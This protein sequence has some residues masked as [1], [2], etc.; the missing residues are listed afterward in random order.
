MWPIVIGCSMEA[1]LWFISK[2]VSK[3]RANYSLQCI[4]ALKQSHDFTNIHK[5]HM[6]S[7]T[8]RTALI[9]ELSTI[10]ISKHNDGNHTGA[11]TLKPLCKFLYHDIFGTPN[12]LAKISKSKKLITFDLIL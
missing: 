3:G 4:L 12:C 10:D 11:Y 5:V 8:T 2:A 9:E 6:H 1:K 7:R